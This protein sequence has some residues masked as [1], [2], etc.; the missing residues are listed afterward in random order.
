MA[1]N[2]NSAGRVLKRSGR[3]VGLAWRQI[4]GIAPRIRH[5]RQDDAAVT[6]FDGVPQGPAGY[7]E[8]G[9]ELSTGGRDG[10]VIVIAL[11]AVAFIIIITYFEAQMPLKTG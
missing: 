6:R 11:L 2:R 4:I 3:R 1:M 5:G 8:P 9:E 10:V 7:V